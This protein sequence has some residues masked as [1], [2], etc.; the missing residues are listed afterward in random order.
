MLAGPAG[1]AAE[2]PVVAGLPY[3]G[4]ARRVVLA[5]KEEGR[6]ELAARLAPALTVAVEAA[7]RGTAAELLVPVPG[8][9]AGRARRGFDPVTVLLQRAGLRATPALCPRGLGSRERAQK[10]RTLAERGH[11]EPERWRVDPRV[12]GRRVVIVD[13]VVTSGATLRTAAL[14]LTRAGAE[15]VGCTAVAATPRRTGASSIPWQ[16]LARDHESHGDK[17]TAQDYRGRKEA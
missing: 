1:F 7:W 12:S 11:L 4:V 8:S 5:L 16:F 3:D 17:V 2:L 14:A 9:R 6:T 15:V 10:S 13:D